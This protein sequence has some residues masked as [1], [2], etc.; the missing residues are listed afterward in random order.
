MNFKLLSSLTLASSIALFLTSCE[1]NDTIS[2]KGKFSKGVFVVNEGNFTHGNA[3]I[4]FFDR[5]SLKVT[6]DLFFLVNNRPLGDIAQSIA[7]FNGKY[8]IVVNNSGKVE[9]VSNSDFTSTGVINGLAQPRYFIGINNQKAYVS[10]WGT[11][12]DGSL[13]VIDLS[14]KSITRTIPTGAGAEKMIK[15]GN[16]VYV[17]NSGGFGSDSTV[18]VINSS[19]DTLVTKIKV[20]YDPQAIVE[21]KNDK[22]WVLCG[23]KWKDDFSGLDKPGSLVR[24]NPSNNS[25]ELT[26]KFTSMIG[27]YD[28]KPLLINKAKDILFYT[29]DGRVYEQS[30]DN[31]T[32]NKSAKINR[33]FYNL[34]LDPKTDMFYGSDISNGTTN[35]WIF[36]YNSSYAKVDSFQVGIYPDE[37][38]FN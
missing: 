35:G 17:T 32:L 14:T 11:G 23:G 18:A 29:L 6:N 27:G 19:A 24:I 9:I 38:F 2:L 28:R 31:T 21:D 1:K 5:D 13:A 34:G 26:L 15:I 12:T 8:Y 20:G 10:Q 36:R 7:E 30:I 22:L 4:S 33:D 16:F 25:V 3:S 37:T